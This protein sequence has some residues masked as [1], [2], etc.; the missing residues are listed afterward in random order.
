VKDLWFQAQL[1]KMERLIALSLQFVEYLLQELTGSACTRT[2]KYP[3][4]L[5][6]CGH[7]MCGS[8]VTKAVHTVDDRSV[9][10]CIEC[11]IA[12]PSSVA[13]ITID[14]VLARYGWWAVVLRDCRAQMSATSDLLSKMRTLVVRD[15]AMDLFEQNFLSASGGGASARDVGISRKLSTTVRTKSSS[16]QPPK[17]H[18]HK[19]VLTASAAQKSSKNSE[20]KKN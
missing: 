17:H 7:A 9:I 15:D 16:K 13:A 6:G 12:S 2:Y 20:S 19:R 18:Q 5:N 8:C 1:I 4:T 3:H 14:G 11:G 10:I